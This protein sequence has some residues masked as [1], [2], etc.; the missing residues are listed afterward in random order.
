MYSIEVVLQMQFLVTLI[1]LSLDFLYPNKID[2]YF[3]VKYEPNMKWQKLQCIDMYS[4]KLH[5]EELIEGTS[6][7]HINFA[8]SH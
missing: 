8:F 3:S 7:S 5:T 2:N 1:R 4:S 6:Q